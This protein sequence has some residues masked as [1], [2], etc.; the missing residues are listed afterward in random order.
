MRIE[1]IEIV[2]DLLKKFFVLIASDPI[3]AER[4]PVSFV[5]FSDEIRQVLPLSHLSNVVG[6]PPCNRGGPTTYKSAF[7]LLRSS[8]EADVLRLKSAGAVVHRPMVVFVS[9]GVPNDEDWR[10]TYSQLVS[11]EFSYY[12]NVVCFNTEGKGSPI[13]A[14]VSSI[15]LESASGANHSGEF[16]LTSLIPF[17][18][19]LVVFLFSAN[20]SAFDNWLISEGLL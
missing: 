16:S 20:V 2:N 17:V 19:S 18:R 5:Y 12:P 3:A 1:S 10:D 4:I 9:A 13:L 14:E 7:T 15:N 8:I 6:I 11:H